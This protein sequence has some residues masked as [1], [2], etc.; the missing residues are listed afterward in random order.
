MFKD[1]YKRIGELNEQLNGQSIILTPSDVEKI[2]L[3]I[4]EL[5]D[6]IDEPDVWSELVE[7]Y[8]VDGHKI[9]YTNCHNAILSHHHVYPIRHIGNNYDIDN[10][11]FSYYHNGEL[12]REV[13]SGNSDITFGVSTGQP[14]NGTIYVGNA[15]QKF[16]DKD[17]LSP[18]DFLQLGKAVYTSRDMFDIPQWETVI[19]GTTGIVQPN[20]V[21]VGK[22][23]TLKN[24]PNNYQYDMNNAMLWCVSTGILSRNG[25]L[26]V[27]VHLDMTTFSQVTAVW[28][29]NGSNCKLNTSNELTQHVNKIIKHSETLSEQVGHA[30]RKLFT[31]IMV[32]AIKKHNAPLFD[33]ILCMLLTKMQ[34]VV[35]KS[36]A[37]IIGVNVDCI[38]IDKELNDEFVGKDIG[39]FKKVSSSY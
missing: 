17:H 2:E 32:I 26:P 33:N 12:I 14:Y 24:D 3:R 8:H 5:N 30:Y 7:K 1:Y 18:D 15:Y 37:K 11:S 25:S 38:E 20:M 36:N 34:F 39:K 35:N 23:N 6:I 29:T 31:V 27:N 21:E 9:N 4:A 22:I 13:H 28:D 10:F 16:L 19:T